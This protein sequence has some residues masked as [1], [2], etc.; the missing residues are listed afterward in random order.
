MYWSLSYSVF[1]ESCLRRAV[2]CPVHPT[3]P[4]LRV[5][6]HIAAGMRNLSLNCADFTVILH[7]VSGLKRDQ[8][9][10]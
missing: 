8:F 7:G 6:L 5:G 1:I 9:E 4:G 3:I 10:K 2:G